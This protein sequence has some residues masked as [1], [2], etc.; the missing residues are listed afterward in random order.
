VLSQKNHR[1]DAYAAANQETVRALV[2]N[3][4]TLTNGSNQAQPITRLLLSKVAQSFTDNFEQ[5]LDPAFVTIGTH[6]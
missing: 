1:R 5:D 4:E 6:N 3:A 2:R